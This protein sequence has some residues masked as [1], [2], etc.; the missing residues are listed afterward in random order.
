MPFS[1]EAGDSPSGSLA[2]T[3]DE[4]KPTESSNENDDVEETPLATAQPTTEEPTTWATETTA[5]PGETKSESSDPSSTDDAAESSQNA[6]LAG[7]EGGSK[8]LGIPA[9]IGV[10]AASVI[11]LAFGGGVAWWSR[12]KINTRGKERYVDLDS[13]L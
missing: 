8:G 9:I 11:L 5:A 12:S 13:Q 3:E 4:P 1:I 10:V 6:E 7:A 2:S